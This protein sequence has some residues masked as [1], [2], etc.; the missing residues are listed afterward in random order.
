M[1]Q[2]PFRPAPA[3]GSRP[4]LPK[5]DRKFPAGE[6]AGLSSTPGLF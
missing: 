3:A 1:G 6:P 5:S 4:L 2:E